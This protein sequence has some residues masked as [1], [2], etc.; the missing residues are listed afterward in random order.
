[1]RR[2]GACHE[3]YLSKLVRQGFKVAVCEQIEDP[4]EAKKRGAKSVVKRASSR[5]VTPGT[6]TE[7]ELLEARGTITWLAS[8]GGAAAGSASP[9]LDISTGGFFVQAIRAASWPAALARLDPERDPAARPPAGD[10]GALSKTA[11]DDWTPASPLP[12]QRFD[13]DN[14]RKRLQTAFNGAATLDAFGAFT[15]RRGRRRRRP[16]RLCRAD[17]AGQDARA[18]AAPTRE[19]ADG[20]LMEIDAGDTAQPRAHPQRFDGGRDGSLLATIDRTVTGAGAR[21]LAEC[22]SAP[23]T[24]PAAIARAPGPGAVLLER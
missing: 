20:A 2:A 7:D 6:L 12:W 5:I 23:L 22:L 3:A 18:L 17:P 15:P 21:L 24:D 1:M 8:G 19:L 9:G 11:L 4:A 14:A 13:S 16:A 10:A